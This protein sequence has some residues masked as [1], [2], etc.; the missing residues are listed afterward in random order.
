MTANKNSDETGIIVAGLL[1]KKF[2]I[3]EDA[4]P[5]EFKFIDASSLRIIS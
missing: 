2:Y 1:N 3:L 5:Y 4:S